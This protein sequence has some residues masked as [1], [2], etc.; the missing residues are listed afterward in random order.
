MTE[1]MPFPENNYE[2]V[3]LDRP[4]GVPFLV[5]PGLEP[6]KCRC[7]ADICLPPLFGGNSIRGAAEAIESG[8]VKA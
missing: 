5:P 2:T 6:I 1:I 8:C 4:F 7:P 3:L